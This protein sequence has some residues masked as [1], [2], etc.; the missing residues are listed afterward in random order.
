MKAITLEEMDNA[1]ILQN[2]YAFQC[3][4]LNKQ[5]QSG[6]QLLKSEM[7]VCG[8][9]YHTVKTVNTYVVKHAK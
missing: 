1:A 7:S 2:A 5:I 6:S 3:D 4:N 8:N 9:I